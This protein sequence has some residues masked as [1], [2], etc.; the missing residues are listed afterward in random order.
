MP[1]A[2]SRSIH[3]RLQRNLNLLHSQASI[4][5][6]AQN[7]RRRRLRQT[8][9]VVAE[10]SLTQLQSHPQIP[11]HKLRSAQP[12]HQVALAT[13]LHSHLQHRQ[14]HRSLQRLLLA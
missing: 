3:N 14:Y 11:K 4:V 9:L 2:A 12:A 1:S 6:P 5:F 13:G 7:R 10:A 8:Y